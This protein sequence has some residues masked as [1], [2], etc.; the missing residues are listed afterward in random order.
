MQIEF[1][2]EPC[3]PFFLVC[4][5]IFVLLA[6]ELVCHLL[7]IKGGAIVDYAGIARKSGIVS[8]KRRKPRPKDNVARD[9]ADN[10]LDLASGGRV[11]RG[12][13]K[14]RRKTMADKSKKNH[15]HGEEKRN[16]QEKPFMPITPYRYA[17]AKTATTSASCAACRSSW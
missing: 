8:R 17:S 2:N 3:S 7:R 9:S 14:I 4:R 15:K 1:C 5:C 13:K 12:R 6:I 10:T 16:T 11:A